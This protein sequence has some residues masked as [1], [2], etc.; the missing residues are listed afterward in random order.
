M[1]QLG[2]KNTALAKV[3]DEVLSDAPQLGVH[4]PKLLWRTV[5]DRTGCSVQEL[6]DEIL[7]RDWLCKIEQAR[8]IRDLKGVLRQMLGEEE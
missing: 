8:T 6:A 4:N 7:R 5:R 3:Y 1:L 2:R